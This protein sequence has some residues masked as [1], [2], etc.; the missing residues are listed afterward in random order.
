MKGDPGRSACVIGGGAESV[1]L[2][3]RRPLIRQDVARPGDEGATV[4]ERANL[5]GAVVAHWIYSVSILVF[6][7]RLL[8][9]PKLGHW[10]GAGVLL[11]A[12]PLAF[13]L[14]KAPSLDRSP[15]YYLQIG[16][17]LTWLVVEFLLD[18]WPGFEFRQ[19]RWIVVPYVMLFFAGCGGMIGVAALAGRGWMIS[20]AIVFL[21][22]GALA[23]VQRAITG[24]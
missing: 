24:M 5:V 6:M 14:L 7:L 21:I 20:A 3:A 23:F 8:Q 16:L 10:I 15:L 18:W 4:M 19:A 12:F 1:R 17:M 13:L 22:M 11:A 2:L 9:L